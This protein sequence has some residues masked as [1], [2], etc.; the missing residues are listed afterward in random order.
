MRSSRIT[1]AHLNEYI[2][3]EK[4]HTFVSD[5]GF[6]RTIT[7][8]ALTAKNGF[9]AIG[10]SLCLP[11]DSFDAEMNESIAYNRARSKLLE[12]LHCIQSN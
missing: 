1:L 6:K 11:E 4:Y 7:V 3:D 2:A 5:V 8:C 9:I 12:I 10:E